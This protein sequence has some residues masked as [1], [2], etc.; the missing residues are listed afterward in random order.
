[1]K[2]KQEKLCEPWADVVCNCSSCALCT[3][4]QAAPRRCSGTGATVMPCA[5]VALGVVVAVFRVRGRKHRASPRSLEPV[6]K[7]SFCL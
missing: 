1:M 2:K 5:L 7:S 6:A 3:N 4:L